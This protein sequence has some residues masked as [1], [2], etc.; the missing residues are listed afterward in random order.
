[1]VGSALAEKPKRGVAVTPQVPAGSVPISGDY[2]ALIIGIDQ[3]QHVPKLQSAVKDAQAVREVLVQRYG[4]ARDHVI[5]LINGQATRERIENALYQVRKKTGPNDSVFIYYAGHG[6]IDQEDQIGYWVPVEGKAQSPGTFISNARIRDEIGRMKAK[7]VYLVADSCFSGTLFASGR[8]LPPLNDKF[9]QR[10]YANKSRWGLT[11]GM[12]E[13]VTDQ[14]KDGHSMFA[15]FFLKLLKEN[16]DP[17]LVPSHIYDQIAPLIGRNTDQQPRSEPL[18]NAGDEGGQFVFRL[19]STSGG[20]TPAPIASGTGPSDEMAAMKKRLEEMEKK[21]SQQAKPPKPSESPKVT[22]LPSYSQPKQ[23]GKEITG[24]DGAPMVLVPAGE[25]IMGSNDGG[26]DE[27]PERRVTLEA[28]YM[29]KYEVTTTRYAAFM[30]ATGRKEPGHWNEVRLASHGDRPV[31]GVT[32]HDA[33]AYCRHYSKRL[34][35]EQ[36]W[37]KAA[38]GTDGRKYPW[39]N[40]EPTS[41]HANFGK[42]GFND[43]GVLVNV[44]SLEEGKSPYGIYDM[45]GNVWEWTSSDYDSNNKVLRGGSWLYVAR[46]LVSTYRNRNLPTLRTSAVGFRCAQDA[47]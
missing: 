44:G 26:A 8:A 2:W 12:N 21:L 35:T 31:V 43:Y 39:G 30:Q 17:Y 27:K 6:Q 29:D 1:M 37:E 40:D 3:Y 22:G 24:K 47:R 25:F 34:P 11:S 5:E 32:W 16:E 45:A 23:T 38:R 19:A 36:E 42:S 18:Q 20:Q 28:F 13:P 7:H 4:F 9:F 46:Y 41:L 15:Y 14:G 33:D 10:L